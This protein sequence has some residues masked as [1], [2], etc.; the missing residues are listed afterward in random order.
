MLLYLLAPFSWLYAMVTHVRNLLY[1]LGWKK[2][3]SFDR[4]VISVG[5]LNVG[6]TGKTPMIEYLVELLK[7][8]YSIAILSRGYGRHTKG[9]RLAGEQDDAFSIGDEPFQFYKKYHQQVSV[10]V[11]ED[12]VAG[13]NKLLAGKPA[14]Q[15]ILLD[16]AFQHRAVKPLF[17]ILL[18]DFSKPFFTDYVLP[19]GRL[20]EPR[21]GSN[22]ADIL[23]VT[24]CKDI[25]VEMETK[26]KK[27]ALSYAGEK[28]VFFSGIRYKDL[29]SLD[30]EAPIKNK[31]I[32]VTG[33]ANPQPMIDYVS[34]KFELIHHFRYD[35]HYEYLSI[36][37]KMIQEKAGSGA[38]VLTTEKDMVKLISP[39]LNGVIDKKL[40]FYLPVEAYFLNNGS[41][42]D[43]SIAKRIK[44]QL[45]SLKI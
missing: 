14:L 10:A 25:S 15:V 36:D 17:S 16:D 27:A 38:S 2:S 31:I 21:M 3:T 11:C 1:D 29:I 12:R 19:M 4:V 13:I 24:K 44:S 8:D 45:N 35:D 5:N 22:R 43:D 42:F 40:W 28:P 7:K 33:I 6:G 18:T 30:G 20:R 23:V 39:A 41:E 32:L 34:S 37:I 9:F 26:V